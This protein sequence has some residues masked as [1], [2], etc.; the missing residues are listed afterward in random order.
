M[1][2][3][4]SSLNFLSVP[5]L[6]DPVLCLNTA[7]GLGCSCGVLTSLQPEPHHQTPC[8]RAGSLGKQPPARP[9]Q[10]CSL[11]TY[12]KKAPFSGQIPLND[13][14]PCL[15]PNPISTPTSLRG[16]S[17][18]PPAGPKPSWKFLPHPQDLHGL[19][20]WCCS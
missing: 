19:R 10:L 16:P 3:F 13:V 6:S 7:G 20:F 15:S 5:K 18:H 2:E 1:G 17:T 9:P 8:Q 4:Q 12:G 11:H 14:L